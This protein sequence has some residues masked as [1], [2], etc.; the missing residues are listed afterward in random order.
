[1]ERCVI[2]VGRIIDHACGRRAAGRCGCGNAACS[3]H[4][5]ARRCAVCDGTWKEPVATLRL[6]DLDLAE[7]FV[8]VD[9]AFDDRGGGRSDLHGL[10]S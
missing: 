1:V 8:G 4:F 9:E 10:D 5:A 2:R 3:R 6:E 7:H